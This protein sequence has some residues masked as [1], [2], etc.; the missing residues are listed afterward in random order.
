MTIQFKRSIETVNSSHLVIDLP[1]SF[2]NRRVE[3]L[4]FTLDEPDAVQPVCH[5][6]PP[7]Q[8]VGKVIELG[9]VMSSAPPSDWGID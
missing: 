4:V 6:I 3:V 5:R 1:D 7:P 9:D 2:I 8:F